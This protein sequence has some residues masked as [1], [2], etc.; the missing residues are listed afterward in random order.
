M[1]TLTSAVFFKRK[2]EET[3][4]VVVFLL[5]ILIY[6]AGILGVIAHVLELILLYVFSGTVFFLLLGHFLRKI[7]VRQ[8]LSSCIGLL[9]S[10]GIWIFAFLVVFFSICTLH[11]RV[12][13]WDDLHYWAIFSKNMAYIN[14]VPTGDMSSSL[15]RDYFPIVQYLYYPVFRILGGYRESA[16]F[17]VDYFLIYLALLPLLIRHEGQSLLSWCTSVLLA[18]ALPFICSFQMLHCLGVDIIMT[19]LFGAGIIWIFDERD[20]LFYFLR[21]TI[22]STALTLSKTTALIFSAVLIGLF[23]VKRVSKTKRFW[24]SFILLSASNLIFYFSWKYFCRLKG[25][26]TYL[27]DNLSSNLDQSGIVFPEYTKET[28]YSFLKSLFTFHLNGSGLGLSAM[29]MLAVFLA[30][31]ILYFRNSRE[32]LRDGTA[33]FILIAGMIGYLLV[34]IYVYLFVFDPWEATSLSSYDRYITTCFGALLYTGFYFLSRIP[35][36]RF[37]YLY[38]CIALIL[39]FTVNYS[40]IAQTLVPSGFRTCY[41]E[42]LARRDRIDQELQSVLP[43]DLHYGDHILYVDDKYD[44]ERSKMIP[45]CSV[46]YVARIIWPDENQPLTEEYILSEAERF[47]AKYVIFLERSKDLLPSDNYQID[48]LYR[49]DPESHTL[50]E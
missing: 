4:P 2:A 18:V 26:T 41:G 38:S 48:H 22:L 23:F 8:Y 28:I 16:M 17:A 1:L 33:L 27:S 29:A 14:G 46:P 44:M 31:F 19:F 21:I 10:P 37:Q 40:Y 13:N 36:M 20:D 25:N 32:K 30:A 11:M 34:L 39:L 43:P 49:F 3:L 24:I 7:P 42:T 15:Y 47:Q 45:Y 5:M 6:I 12:T 50:S 9:R 35:L